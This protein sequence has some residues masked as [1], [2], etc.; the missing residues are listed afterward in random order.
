MSTATPA[1]GGS[2]TSRVRPTTT[3]VALNA[4]DGGYFEMTRGPIEDVSVDGVFSED[5]YTAVRLLVGRF[6]RSGGF[7]WPTSSA[8]TATTSISFTNHRVHPGSPSTFEDISIRGVFCS[9]SGQGMTVDPAEPGSSHMRLHLD[10]RPRGRQFPDH[11]R[12]PPHGER[13]AGGE[14]RDRT[15]GDGRVPA[16]EQRLAHQPHARCD[17]CPDEQGNDRCPAE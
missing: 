9:K 1:G 5:G 3:L 6:A 15:G 13:L 4:D 14:H 12:L 17:P 2:R 8:P 16:N 11:R 7:N 10:R